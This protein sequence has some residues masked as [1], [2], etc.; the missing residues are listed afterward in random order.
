MSIVASEN[1]A[2]TPML[3]P[4]ISLADFVPRLDRMA[5][6]MARGTALEAADLVQE[7]LLAAQRSFDRAGHSRH[8]LRCAKFAMLDWARRNQR[9]QDRQQRAVARAPSKI[10]VDALG[11]VDVADLLDHLD[12][13]PDERL[14]L[15]LRVTGATGAEIARAIGCSKSWVSRLLAGAR[16]KLAAVFG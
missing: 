1:S 12:L 4:P 10:A 8:A 11:A 5:R 6:R 16:E 15:R 7:G 9:W 13:H 14:A 3:T 2:M